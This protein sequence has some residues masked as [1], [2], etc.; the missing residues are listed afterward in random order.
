MADSGVRKNLDKMIA[1]HE[2]LEARA[3]KVKA[4]IAKLRELAVAEDMAA[5]KDATYVFAHELRQGPVK[6][7]FDGLMDCWDRLQ[8]DD[9]KA[10][11]RFGHRDSFSGIAVDERAFLIEYFWQALPKFS[12]I[13]A[14]ISAL[15]RGVDRPGN[16]FI[17]EPEPVE[18]EKREEVAA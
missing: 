15:N 17:D 14:A 8:E 16:I 5:L 9:P 7:A 10:L 13:I 12:N 18:E 6:V 4:D 1:D 2:K 11:S 3:G